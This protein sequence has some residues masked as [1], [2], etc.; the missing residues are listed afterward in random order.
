M[1]EQK[2]DWGDGKEVES[3]WFKF[4]KV[5]DKIKGTKI[6]QDRKEGDGAF[7]PQLITTL[8]LAD[9]NLW[10]VGVSES[11]VGTIARLKNCKIG[12]VIG[13][14]FDSEGD[15]PKKGFHKVKN[16]KVITFGMDPNYDEMD[17]GEEVKKTPMEQ[18]EEAM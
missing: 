4:E 16:L 9:G 7:G 6:S 15:A 1:V 13:I 8:K 2:D 11:K 3:N 10:F 12:E 17:G 14:K 5:G 18:A